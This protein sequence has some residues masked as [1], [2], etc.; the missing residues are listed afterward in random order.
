MTL[1]RA[2]A[3]GLAALAACAAVVITIPG[4]ASAASAYRYWAY[5]VTSPHGTSWQYSQRGPASEYPVDGEVQGWRFAVQVDA[6]NGLLPRAAPDFA[7]LCKSTPAKAGELRVGLVIDF[8]LATDAPAHEKPPG[9]A[10]PGCVYVRD[11]KTGTDVL[12]A[13][14]AVRIGTGSDAGLVCGIDGYP[15]TECAVAVAANPAPLAPTPSPTPSRASPHVTAS[16]H[17]ATTPAATTL[18]ATAAPA[19]SAAPQSGLAQS[20]VP[21][22]S[23]VAPASRVPAPASASALS[24]A[25]LRSNT[26]H[27]HGVAAT[28]IGGV[29][30]IVILGGAA[31]WRTRARGR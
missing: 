5:Y 14:A 16:S 29:A 4:H 6:G 3:F 27:S 15:K 30:L 28:T 8:G 21:A 10:V 31:I 23:P 18:P 25:A 17:A 24:L 22:Q 19:P 1:T 13:A 12:A 2:A 11:G 7:A 20:P 9:E 26:R